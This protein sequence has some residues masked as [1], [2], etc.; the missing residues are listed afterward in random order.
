MRLLFLGTA[1]ASTLGTLSATGAHAQSAPEEATLKL[2]TVIVT[3]QRR[4][5]SAQ[6]VGIALS[7]YDG[8]ELIRKGISGI[9]ALE[10][11]SPNLEMENQFGSAATAFSIRGVGFR[12]YATLNAPTVGV[13][14]DDVGFAVP[15]MT[16]GV[17]FDVKRVEVLRGPQGTLYGRNTTGG[18]I[19]II[20][21][22]PTQETEAGLTTEYGRFDH[23]QAE[24]YLSGAL[25]DHLRGR[26]SGIT[27]QGGAWQINRETGVK[28]GNADKFA[29]RLQLEADL[30]SNITALLNV[31]GYQDRSDGLGLQL[32]ND[33]A[34]GPLA[35]AQ[36]RQ[37]SFGSSAAF[38][39][40]V[41]ITPTTKPF[42]NFDG[43]GT[44]LTLNASLG[45]ADLTYIGSYETLSRR[46]FA[47]YDALSLGAAGV[48]FDSSIDDIT[49]EVRLVSNTDGPLSW[50]G[51]VFYAHQALDEVYQSDFVAS[52]GPGFAVTTPYNQTVQTL[53]VYGQLEYQLNDKLRLSGGLRFEDENRHLRNL[54]TFAL[55]T[56]PLN[57]ANGTVDG[58][59]ENRD[60]SL[61]Q[62]TGK[63]EV[64]YQ[65]DDGVLLYASVSRG[66]KSGGFTAYNTLNPRAVD[67]FT[68]EELIAYETGFKFDL[69][70][71][72][73]RLNASA[74]YYDY[75]DQQ[76][77]SAIFDTNFNAV[78]GRIINAP[79]SKITGGEVELVWQAAPGLHISQSLGLK[80][81]E[82]KKFDDLDVV[83]SLIAG[84]T[85]TTDRSGQSLGL[86]NISY[87][88]AITYTRPINDKLY[89]RTAADYSFR[90]AVTPPLLGP[91]YRVDN[92]WLVNGEMAIGAEDGQ[93]EISLWGRNL[94][95]RTYDETRN[96]F[97][98]PGAVADVAAP[99]LPATYGVRLRLRR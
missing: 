84:A 82:F 76:V 2:D 49:Q 67:P 66:I 94:F 58:T 32:F 37:T 10:N 50:V 77:Q 88:G 97:I 62:V 83:A 75:R 20:S 99:G 80:S 16:Q 6:D 87:Q 54:G 93:W 3:A 96:F 43:W 8:D 45:G 42:R 91:I 18:A 21:N 27:T 29:A 31:H 14:V 81:G 55:A 89:W 52:F 12:D 34:F 92:Y 23:F 22:R 28:L 47:D 73:V 46:E 39:G 57:F 85:V 38:A 74:F 25:G 24:G 61:S 36:H 95:N 64:E 56:G 44:S 48:F 4:E 71:G 68:F 17:L 53:G 65:P 9:N 90:D 86:A 63:A 5:Q 69:L 72:R 11:I 78:V 40:L 33:S 35:H 26:L 30:S 59:R 41:G 98:A 7:A 15:I 13:Y 51:G 79:K 60:Q 70:E 1:L 19:K